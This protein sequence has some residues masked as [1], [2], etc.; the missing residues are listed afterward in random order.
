MVGSFSIHLAVVDGVAGS[1]IMVGADQK[2]DDDDST[3]SGLTETV[4][5][6]SGL[7]EGAHTVVV[8]KISEGNLLQKMK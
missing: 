6:A 3:H 7:D 2:D 5:V 4:V 8:W 1:P